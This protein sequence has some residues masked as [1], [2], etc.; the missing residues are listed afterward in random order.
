MIRKVVTLYGTVFVLLI[1]LNFF[2]PR[3]MPGGPI[4]YLEGLDTGP[5]LTEEQKEM[6]KEYYQLDG[7]LQ[8]QLVRY[9]RGLLTFDFGVS[10]MHKQPVT[11]LILAHLPYTL[12]IVGISTVFSLILGILLGLWSGWFYYQRGDRP[13]MMFMMAVGALPEFLVGMILLLVFSVYL[14]LFPMSGASTPFLE[15]ETGWGIMLDALR[16]ATLPI[17]SLTILSISST[18]LLV[19]NEAIQV[20]ASPF[21]EFAK[22]KGLSNQRLLYRHIFK[23]ALLPVFTLM[24]IRIGTHFTGA[25]FIETL[26]SYPGIGNLL[27]EA[28]LSRDYPLMHGLFFVFSVMI[29]ALNAFADLLY[30]KLDPRVKGGTVV[31]KRL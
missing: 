30:P 24:M 23:N 17:A 9:L 13:L 1:L 12:F 7:S 16:H 2:L 31:E 29:L 20:I 11:D 5:T 3:L 26:F 21:I 18:Y 15:N 10:F 14:G 6:L 4:E 19:R 27:K 28:V 22:M 8:E 25:I